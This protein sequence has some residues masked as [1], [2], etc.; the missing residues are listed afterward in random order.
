MGG[1]I[2]PKFTVHGAQLEGELWCFEI[3]FYGFEM[4]W[5]SFLP[6]DRYHA[7]TIAELLSDESMRTRVK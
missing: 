4:V 2:V 3:W 5:W 1:G 6:R 7:C